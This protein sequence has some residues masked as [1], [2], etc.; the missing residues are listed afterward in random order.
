MTKLKVSYSFAMTGA[1]IDTAIPAL[2]KSVAG[3]VANIQ[4]LAVSVLA[5]FKAHGD[6][7]TATRRANA[8]VAALGK[9][10]RSAS[11]LA[12]FEQ[13]GP[14]VFNTET[15]LLVV[16]FTG[17]S[18]VKDHKKI[19]LE[20]SKAALW[21]EAKPPED[22]KPLADWSKALNGL[23]AKA[24]KDIAELGDASKVDVAQLAT[25]EQLAAG[26]KLAPA[27]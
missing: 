11:L 3:L 24:K 9:G 12:W 19:D 6:K 10:M 13:N 14:F 5:D 27:I 25:L 20:V 26:A 18:P 4:K 7:P 23:I 2:E 22:Y 17:L 21:Q 1:M 8:L 16:G 15:K